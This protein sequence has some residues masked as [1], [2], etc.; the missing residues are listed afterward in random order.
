MVILSDLIAVLAYTADVV[1]TIG[2]HIVAVFNKLI[3]FGIYECFELLHIF[4]EFLTVALALEAWYTHQVMITDFHYLTNFLS[5]FV[6]IAAIISLTASG[7]R[8]GNTHQP[9]MVKSG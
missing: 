9:R 8:N 2:T 6:S 5:L 1:G 7:R 3:A 4:A